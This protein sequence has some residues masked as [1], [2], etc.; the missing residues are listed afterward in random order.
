ML[1]TMYKKER[2]VY[3]AIPP[4]FFIKKHILNL[5]PFSVIYTPAETAMHPVENRFEKL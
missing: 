3:R 5:T 4:V 1:I 2:F